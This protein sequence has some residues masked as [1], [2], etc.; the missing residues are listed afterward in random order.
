MY[1]GNSPLV[2]LLSQRKLTLTYW[3]P[4]PKT[5][6]NDSS[7]NLTYLPWALRLNVTRGMLSQAILITD[8]RFC[9]L[10]W[11]HPVSGWEDTYKENWSVPRLK[12]ASWN[13]KMHAC[14]KHITSLKSC[15]STRVPRGRCTG[16]NNPVMTSSEGPVPRV[17]QTTGSV[18]PQPTLPNC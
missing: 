3:S 2:R 14:C 9:V 12:E 17:G 10:I 1:V 7:V 18:H 8:S 16:N 11:T 15:W 5:P 6:W 13:E 4:G